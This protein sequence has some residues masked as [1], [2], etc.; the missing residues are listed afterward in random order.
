MNGNGHKIT[1]GTYYI[2][3]YELWKSHLNARYSDI[4][5][6]SGVEELLAR[7]RYARSDFQ[8][9]PEWHQFKAFKAVE[10]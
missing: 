4:I 7:M 9:K 1:Y 8:Y 6:I 3:M 5:C 2:Y 10:I